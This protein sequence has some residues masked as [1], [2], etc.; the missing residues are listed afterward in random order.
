MLDRKKE[1]QIDRMLDRQKEGQIDR[2]KVDIIK[3]E[4]IHFV[5]ACNPPTDPGR[6]PLSHR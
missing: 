5:G 6:K 1:G 2:W 3:A 4:R